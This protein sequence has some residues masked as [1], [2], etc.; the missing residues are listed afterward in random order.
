MSLIN[1]RHNGPQSFRAIHITLHITIYSSTKFICNTNNNKSKEV[2][3][4][5][6]INDTV[7]NNNIKV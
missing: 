2:F 7:H 5:C 3:K 4:I 1:S 6:V